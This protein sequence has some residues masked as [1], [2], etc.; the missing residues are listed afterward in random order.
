MVREWIDAKL[1][2]IAAK[3]PSLVHSD[4]ASFN[5]GYN[6]GYKQ[7]VL[8]LDRLLEAQEIDTDEVQD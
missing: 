7:A 6:S 5:C 1:C 8:E 4:P 3:L 2:E